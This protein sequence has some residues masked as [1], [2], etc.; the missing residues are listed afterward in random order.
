LFDTIAGL[1][2]HILVIHVVVVIGPLTAVLATAYAVRP[3]WR[4]ALRWWLVGSAVLT[5]VTGAVAGA[6]GEDLERRVRQIPGAS[7]SQ[8]ALVHD[9]AEAG[10]LA[11][12]LC[13]LLMLVVLAAV[14]ALLPPVG[15]PRLGGRP[16]ALLTSVVL[17]LV[18]VG[19]LA[20]VTLT[21]HS[22]AKASWADKVQGPLPA[23][24]PGGG[25]D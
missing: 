16:M 17:V 5:G 10:D 18:S 11:R 4:L 15:G 24:G 25:H 14:W 19:T 21:G 13:L 3:T 6:S 23:E 12:A 1:P 20:S 2:V 9:H 7:A 8:L 22:G